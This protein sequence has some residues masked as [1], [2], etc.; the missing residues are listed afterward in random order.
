MTF[1][2]D[3]VRCSSNVY[4]GQ[5]IPRRN[6]AMDLDYLVYTF[7]KMINMNFIQFGFALQFVLSNTGN[8]LQS[9]DTSFEHAEASK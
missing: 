6:K 4:I 2:R 1:F 3:V 8:V 5:I 7:W 9:Q